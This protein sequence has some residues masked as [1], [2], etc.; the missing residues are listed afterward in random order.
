[1]VPAIEYTCAEE[2]NSGGGA[3]AAGGDAEGG[4]AGVVDGFSPGSVLR[5]MCGV[6]LG[7]DFEGGLPA[8]PR[9]GVERGG[10]FTTS[11]PDLLTA[12]ASFEEVC[13]PGNVLLASS[14]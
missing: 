11:S 7:E 3:T 6:A 14:P 4:A 13:T 10:A 1:M 8:T 5:S 12:P 2:E 9:E